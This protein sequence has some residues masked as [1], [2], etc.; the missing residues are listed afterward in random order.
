[1]ENLK[2]KGA[3]DMLPR[4]TARFR[5]I[6]D[7]FRRTCLAWSY[8]EVRTPTLEYLNLFTSAGTLTPKMLSKVYSFL[9]W[10]GWS[11]ERV[12][13]RPD[14]TIPVARLYVENLI[15]EKTARLFYVTNVFAFEE[16]GKESREKWQGG[17]ELLGS[18]T[19]VAD[20]ELILL[21]TEI[22]R[23]LGIEDF[24]LQLSHAGL[25]KSL[26]RELR[27]DTNENRDL[28]TQ[29]L[30]FD[31]QCLTRIQTSNSGVSKVLSLLLNSRGKTSGF[32]S[33]LKTLPKIP[34]A[35]K[36]EI[37]NFAEVSSLLDATNCK[38]QIDL[39]SVRSFEYYTGLCFTFLLNEEK[40]A[41]GGRYDNLIPII[42]NG[43][44]PACGFA[45]Y[46]DPLIHLVQPQQ[47]APDKGIAITIESVT[48]TATRYAFQ[49]AAS[50]RKVGYVTEF[51][52]SG[53][54][55]KWRWL[56]TVRDKPIA[57]RITDQT[58]NQKFDATSID[59]V[60]AI[61]GDSA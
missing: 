21:A 25:L 36:R 31:W 53:D 51:T 9:D 18:S 20:V 43:D 5:Y 17:V 16:T 15:Q 30:D 28:V 24:E 1:M 42:G 49:L 46:I 40:I 19:P 57:F 59:A 13:L 61:L 45:L 2:C 34:V 50:L 33:N 22:L 38:Y 54:K 47:Q 7:A 6:E 60:T 32:L 11:G 4:D 35:L 29:I 41:G 10:D 27:P 44:T 52:I 58:Q 26:L 3:R 8:Q 37:D 55:P 39:T 56:V 23:S 14:G 12:V 48:P